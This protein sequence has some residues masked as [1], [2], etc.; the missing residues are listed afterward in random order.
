MYVQV[1]ISYSEAVG[2]VE[3]SPEHSELERE[4]SVSKPHLPNVLVDVFPQ[5][6]LIPCTKAPP[7]EPRL[8]VVISALHIV[9]VHARIRVFENL[10][11]LTMR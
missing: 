10:L 8:D 4:T 3:E 11:W 2:V 5:L 7:P 9:G 6:P 1:V